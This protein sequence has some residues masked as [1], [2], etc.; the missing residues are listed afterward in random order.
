ML[1]AEDFCPLLIPPKV[2]RLLKLLLDHNSTIILKIS[3]HLEEQER[4]K[5]LHSTITLPK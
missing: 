2:M 1:E 5:S 3:S 4:N